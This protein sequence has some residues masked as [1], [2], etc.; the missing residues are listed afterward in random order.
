V[1]DPANTRLV[2]LLEQVWRATAELGASLDEDQWKRPTECPGW[3]VQDNLVH[4]TAVERHLLGDPLPVADLPDDLPHVR[5]RI[6]RMNEKWIASRRD[7]SGRDAL[8]EFVATV[9]ARVE[10]LR[11]QDDA[12]FAADS[13]TPVGPGTVAGLLGLRVLDCWVHEQDMRRAVGRSGDLDSPAAEHTLDTLLLLFPRVVG[14]N[15]GA[16][17]GSTVVLSLDGPLH[18]V[19]VVTVA[20]GHARLVGEPRAQATVRLSLASDTYER[21]ACGR[22]DPDRALA[23]GAVGVQ[24]DT[25]LAAQVVRELNQMF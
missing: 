6:G 15:A 20:D 23:S 2:D 9:S 7:W 21:L 16:P 14:K 13:W 8:D 17:D 3:T 11:A 18:R 5:N 12:A 4:V 19:L 22:I 10:Q 1:T 24:G 25:A